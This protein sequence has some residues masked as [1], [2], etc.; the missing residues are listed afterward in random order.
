VPGA[1]IFDPQYPDFQFW[2]RIGGGTAQ[3]RLGT[4]EP[5][6]IPETV[7]VSGALP[8]RSEVF[9]RII[10]P[11]PNGYL[12]PTIVKFTTSRVEVWIEQLGTGEIRYYD[13]AG[14]APGVDELPG[15]FD[16][17]GFLP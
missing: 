12:W 9:I 3:Q 11:R 10:G 14:A 13:L 7:C 1:P 15:L 2:V 5:F 17:L 8:G 4:W 6:C 16:R